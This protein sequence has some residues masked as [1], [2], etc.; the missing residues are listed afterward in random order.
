[1][2]EDVHTAIENRVTERTSAGKKIHTG[3]SRN[4]QLMVDTRLYTKDALIE[5]AGTVLDLVETLADA[6]EEHDDLVMPGYT[7]MQQAMPTTAGTWLASHAAALLDDLAML[8]AAYQVND[9][10]PLGAAAGFGTTLDIDRER[11][12]ELLGF[13]KLQ[14][15]PITC[16]NSRGKTELKTVQ[17]VTQVA[18][19]LNRLANELM[20]YSTAEYGFIDLPDAYC[21]GS[22]IMPQKKN[23]DVLEVAI[24]KLG[25]VIGN[26]HGMEDILLNAHST[27][28]RETQ[29]TKGAF[30]ET[31]SIVMDTASMMGGIVDGMTFDEDAIT[32]AMQEEIYAAY[33]ANEMV[34]DGVP[35][36]EA[37]REVKES[38]AYAEPSPDE[39]PSTSP[40]RDAIEEQRTWWT[41]RAEAYGEA[42]DALL[43]LARE[44][45]GQ[46]DG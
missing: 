40:D 37:Y 33:T 45:A 9:Q 20:L 4:D 24:G 23:P 6:A 32:D 22:S 27:F 34:E 43:D 15:N 25:T 16:I 14:E 30:M 7:H 41:D 36:R 1:A 21:T 8:Q 28:G 29:E 10:N 35:F 46:E 44:N 18:L 2:D 12:T 38:E 3:R 26:E 17:A 13:G 19:S 39:I 5:V 11:T 42:V 31:L